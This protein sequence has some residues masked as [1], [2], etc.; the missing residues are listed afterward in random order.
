VTVTGVTLTAAS[1]VLATAQIHI[2]GNSVSGIVVN[3]PGSSFTI[4]LSKAVE[5]N[6]P[7]AWFVLS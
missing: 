1:L 6:A 5:V 3:V 2:A 4:F 7:I